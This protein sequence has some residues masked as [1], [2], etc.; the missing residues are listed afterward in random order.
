MGGRCTAVLVALSTFFLSVNADLNWFVL[1]SERHKLQV[2]ESAVTNGEKEACVCVCVC[3]CVATCLSPA[4]H[5]A[6]Y[7]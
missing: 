5:E 2:E 6:D 4:T 1:S 7:S 3:V